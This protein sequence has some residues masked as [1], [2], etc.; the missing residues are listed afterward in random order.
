MKGTTKLQYLGKADPQEHFCLSMSV[1]SFSDVGKY[2][3]FLGKYNI[4][5][6]P[7]I[8]NFFWVEEISKLLLQYCCTSS[9]TLFWKSYFCP[10]IQFSWSWSKIKLAKYWKSQFWPISWRKFESWIFWQKIEVWYSVLLQEV[11][12][13][14]YNLYI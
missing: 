14:L 7:D 3:T 13:S 11:L 12:I 2:H 8:Y 9:I 4:V 10:K 1:T 6:F 5:P